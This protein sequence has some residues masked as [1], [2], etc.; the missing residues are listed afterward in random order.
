M[1][2]IAAGIGAAVKWFGSRRANDT[3][4]QQG[5]NPVIRAMLGAINEGELEEFEQ[6]VADDCRVAINSADVT[7]E[8]G[9][10]SGWDLWVDGIVDLRSAFPG[11]RW[12][13]YD[14]LSGKDD[15]RD[16]VAIRF[17]STMVVDGQTRDLE[18]AGF[19]VVEDNM[20]TE[21]HQVADYDTY[22]LWRRETG[23][24]AIGN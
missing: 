4:K 9:L 8:E 2:L 3:G 12:E 22:N 20:L 15:D 5:D 17:V 13:L 21:W 11:I 6:Y 24:E 10:T 18:V 1:V 14:E 19:G 7:R 16:K 23:E